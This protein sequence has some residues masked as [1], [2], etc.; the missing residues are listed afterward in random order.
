MYTFQDY[1]VKIFL[2]IRIC[3]S[4]GV[5]RN[6]HKLYTVVPHL[7]TALTVRPSVPEQ[8]SDTISPRSHPGGDL[9]DPLTQ[10][11]FTIHLQHAVSSLESS[12]LCR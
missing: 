10:H 1:G 7:G 5:T 4:H 11:I 8:Q 6:A 3:N 9:S 2:S 12:S